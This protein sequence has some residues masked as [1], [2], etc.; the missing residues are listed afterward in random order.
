MN[1]RYPLLENI[2]DTT[3]IQSLNPQSTSFA[4]CNIWWERSVNIYS[5]KVDTSYPAPEKNYKFFLPTK[6]ISLAKYL[7]VLKNGNHKLVDTF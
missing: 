5:Q 3:D 1:K 4:N 2:Y 7:S 6:K